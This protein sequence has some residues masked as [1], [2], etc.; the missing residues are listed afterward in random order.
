MSV[1]HPC[2]L[3]THPPHTCLWLPVAKPADLSLRDFSHH[4]SIGLCLWVELVDKY[5]SL[6]ASFIGDIWVALYADSQKS[7]VGLSS[8]RPQQSPAHSFTLC[9]RAFAPCSLSHLP[10]SCSWDHLPFKPLSWGLLLGETNLTHLPGMN[11]FGAHFLH[12]SFFFSFSLRPSL[13]HI[14][15]TRCVH[16]HW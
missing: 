7:S 16:T 5:S 12:L 2:S 10:S 8:R 4:R 3:S 15:N 14:F 6:L 1:W 13:P 9:G 11:L